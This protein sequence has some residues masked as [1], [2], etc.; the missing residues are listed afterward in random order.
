MMLRRPENVIHIG[1]NLLDEGQKLGSKDK[2]RCFVYEIDA[3]N[4]EDIR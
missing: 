3:S 2:S 1:T 4:K